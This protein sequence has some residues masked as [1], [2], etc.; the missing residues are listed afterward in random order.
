MG[1][2]YMAA[3][4]EKVYSFMFIK[5]FEV[6]RF[7]TELNISC[8]IVAKPDLNDHVPS[9]PPKTQP[10]LTGFSEEMKSQQSDQRK[11]NCSAEI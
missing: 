3:F 10:F 4:L 6:L 9:P 5:H 8:I 2:I 11:A 7:L 1:A